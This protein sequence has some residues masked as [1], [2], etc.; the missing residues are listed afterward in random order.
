MD[1]NERREKGTVP[2]SCQRGQNQVI[3]TQKHLFANQMFTIFLEI[4]LKIQTG[5][6]RIHQESGEY[7]FRTRF[8]FNY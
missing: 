1:Y 3:S 8:Q 5:N 4:Y 7:Q 2:R 6:E